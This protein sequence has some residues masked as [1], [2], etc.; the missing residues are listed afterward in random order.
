MLFISLPSDRAFFSSAAMLA[1]FAG[2]SVESKDVSKVDERLLDEVEADV[3]WCLTKLLD[4]I[5][6]SM[7]NVETCGFRV[8]FYPPPKN[9]ENLRF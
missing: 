1:P 8:A 4:N 5:Q 2:P 7:R 9:R 3:Y 6:V